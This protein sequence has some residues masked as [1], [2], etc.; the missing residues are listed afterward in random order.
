MASCVLDASAILAVVYREPGHE[1]VR[2][3]L[4]AAACSLTNIAEVATKLAENG[5]ERS[6][7]QSLIGAFEFE[8]HGFQYGDAI[9]IGFMRPLTKSAG[10]SLG[11]RACL[12]L[13]KKLGL[14]AITADRSW[15]QVA[16]AVG[17]EIRVVR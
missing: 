14:P 2:P 6:E 15:A 7:V 1:A 17:V 10:L 9:E 5:V 3:H 4:R 12:H 16:D 8:C 13:S 11:D